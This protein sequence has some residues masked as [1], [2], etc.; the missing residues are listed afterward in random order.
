MP[1]E[2]LIDLMVK[3]VFFV[4]IGFAMNKTG[5]MPEHAQK[6]MADMLVCV[7]MP[8]NMLAVGNSPFEER[9]ATN[10]L[11]SAGV[12]IAYY[13]VVITLGLLLG[14]AL[15]VN[16]HE[17]QVFT[18]LIT[19]ANV[20]YI[21]F[22]IAQ[23]LFGSEGLMYAMVGQMVFQI[24]VYSAGVRLVAG[25][26]FTIKQFITQPLT[27]AVVV[28]VVLFIS[29]LRLPGTVLNPVRQVGDMTAPVSLFIVGASL[30][31]IRFASLWTSGRVW[32]VSLLRQLVIP[33]ALAGVLWLCGLRGIMPATA[34]L[35][36]GLPTAT[37]M[38]IL[39]KKHNAGEDWATRAIS[40]GAILMAGTLPLLALVS[41]ALF[42]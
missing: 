19:F 12:F 26:G 31:K 39:E 10:M 36:L 3:M 32:L 4:G 34:T 35:T 1:A 11:I 14:R 8:L 18:A 23:S 6:M 9:L 28:S 15:R 13:A 42:L 20:G 25:R 40:Q 37:M 17:S 27:I 33:L 7:V 29:P 22:P 24:T 21:G 5:L 2:V 41:G 38:V 16:K 30:G